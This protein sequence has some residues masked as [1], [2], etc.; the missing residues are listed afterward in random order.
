[1]PLLGAHMSIA[2]GLDLAFSRIREIGGESLQIYTKNQRQWRSPPLEDEAVLRFRKRRQESGSMP[3]AV[4]DAYLINLASPDP[5]TIRMSVAA[6]ADE[7]TRASRLGIP[8]LIAHPGS[9]LGEGVSS[10]TKKFVTHLDRAIA[11]ADVEDVTVLLEITAGQGTNLGS[12]F[13]EI[14]SMIGL[15]RFG[16]RLGVCFDTCHAFAAGYDL[17]TPEDY[18]ATFSSFDRAIGLDRIRFFHLNDSRLPLGSRVDRH[19]HIGQGELGLEPFR[20][21]LNDPRFERHPMALETPKGKDLRND[22]R[23]LRVLR[24]LIE[25]SN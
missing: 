23:N 14:G 20:L 8:F 12:D 4:H 3:V 18:H 21:L 2:G 5:E 11:S 16:R 24:S 15:S 13:E 19:A 10:G 9:H 6:F 7:L 17:R 22:R 25:R 1:L